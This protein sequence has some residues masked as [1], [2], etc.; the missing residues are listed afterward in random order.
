MM[1]LVIFASK[2]RT[3]LQPYFIDRARAVVY[4]AAVAAESERAVATRRLC[5]L[6]GL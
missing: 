2:K 1:R 5:A 3:T 6:R 4:R